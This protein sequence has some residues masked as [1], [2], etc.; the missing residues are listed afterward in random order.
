VDTGADLGLRPVPHLQAE[1]DVLEDRHVL[2]RRVVLE[3]EADPA[4]LWRGPCDV[5]VGDV[6]GTAVGPLQPGDDPQ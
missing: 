4:F 6:D 3:H 5:L 2:E 1:R